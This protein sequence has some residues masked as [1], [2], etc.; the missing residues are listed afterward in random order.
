[1]C[2]HSGVGRVP[3][4]FLAEIS[5]GLHAVLEAE[6]AQTVVHVVLHG[7]LRDVETLADFPVG[8]TLGGALK[9]FQLSVTQVSGLR[10]SWSRS[11]GSSRG[12][13][14]L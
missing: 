1:M 4:P 7:A 3:K 2:A 5:G 14:G 11:R 12:A 13:M 8:Q 9:N 10:R 6:L